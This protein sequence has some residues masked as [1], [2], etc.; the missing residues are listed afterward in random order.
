[1]AQRRALTFDRLD[2]VMPE[3][4]RLLEG[5]RTA[6]RWSLVLICNHLLT[7]VQGSVTGFPVSAPW[8]VRTTIAPFVKRKI[9]RTCRMAEGVKLPEAYLPRAGLDARA[10]AEDLRAAL[11]LYAAHTGPLAEHPFFGRLSRDEWT[12]LHCIHCAHHLS[13]VHP[14]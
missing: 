11:H 4:D 7:A 14:D 9:V 10:E 2:Q 12:R 13:F 1:M 5:H 3:L 6:G 8:L